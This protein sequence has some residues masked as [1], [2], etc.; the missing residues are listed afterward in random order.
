M[1]L[2]HEIAFSI[3]LSYLLKKG[4]IGSPGLKPF[5]PLTHKDVIDNY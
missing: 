1:L 5:F 2:L 4:E 3:H